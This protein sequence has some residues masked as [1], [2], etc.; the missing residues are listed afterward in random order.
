MLSE[1]E[2]FD[3]DTSSDTGQDPTRTRVL[4]AHERRGDGASYQPSSEKARLKAR[5]ADA[6]RAL[7]NA[8]QARRVAR[9]LVHHLERQ[10][11]EGTSPKG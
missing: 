11:D 3:L 7:R 1:Y 10:L 9:Q 5:L 2:V 6:R 4:T 8:D